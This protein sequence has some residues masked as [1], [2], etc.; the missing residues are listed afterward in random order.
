VLPFQSR[1]AKGGAV[2]FVISRFHQVAVY[3]NGTQPNAINVNI[4]VPST[5]TP[6]GVPLINDAANRVYRGLDPSLQPQDR[7]E[8]VRFDN[9][10]TYLVICAVRAHFV[11]DGMFGF[12]R[13]L[14][15]EDD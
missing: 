13:V 6:A 8:V 5:G 7:V 9:P 10:G 1:I 12:V 3:G 4:T 2:N 11:D 15:G 14:A